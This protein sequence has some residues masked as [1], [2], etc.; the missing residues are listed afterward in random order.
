M[1]DS[2]K[3]WWESFISDQTSIHPSQEVME[4]FN[5]DF[6]LPD[7]DQQIQNIELEQLLV[8][9][10]TIDVAL[11]PI[12]ESELQINDTIAVISEDASNF[13][14]GTIFDIDLDID[15]TYL[16]HIHYYYE[17]SDGVWKLMNEK[18]PG[19]SGTASISS[20]L[21]NNITFTKKK[22]LPERTKKK[23]WKLIKLWKS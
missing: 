20:V 19:S 22:K 16:Y 8:P 17:N 15:D 21:L 14:I 6:W 2:N 13:W 10:P 4:Q 18:K 11:H 1:D 3:R 12:V 23:L 7:V 9:P 5:F